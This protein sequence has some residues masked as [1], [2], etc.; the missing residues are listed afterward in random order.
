M[1]KRVMILAPHPDE[2]HCL[3]RRN[4]AALK[5]GAKVRVVYLTTAI[6]TNWF[7]RL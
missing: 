7:Y 4:P 2:R 1:M 3:R 6:I 5:A